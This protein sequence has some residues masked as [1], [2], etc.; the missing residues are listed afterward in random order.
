MEE[1][2][3][4]RGT[5]RAGIAGAS[6]EELMR[7]TIH[8][9]AK[10]GRA[11][12]IGVW[13]EQ[14]SLSSSEPHAAA[15][16]RGLVW[17]PEAGETPKEWERLSLEPPLPQELLASG[18]TVE[19][20]LE[21]SLSR[22]MIGPLVGLRRA[23]WTPIEGKSHLRGLLLTGTRRKQAS[24][25]REL[26]ESVAA[27]LALALE[28]DL[29]QH[30]GQERQA[31]LRLTKHILAALG[32]ETSTDIV[33][34]QLAANC[35]EV[36][37]DGSGAGASFAVIGHGPARAPNSPAAAE[38]KFVWESGDCACTRSV[39]REP[40]ASL[41][42]AALAAGRVMAAEPPAS[43]SKEG[44]ARL[45]AI[46]LMNAGASL[47]VLVAGISQ[48]ASPLATLER[49]E[50]RAM[51]AV[52]AL[53][54]RSRQAEQIRHTTRREALL[55]FSPEATVLLDARGNIAS[56]NHSAKMLL[57]EARAERAPETRL[58]RAQPPYSKDSAWCIGGRFASLFC[59]RVQQRVE[60][61]SSRALAGERKEA[62]EL[63][64]AC[65]DELI[66]G[67]RVRVHAPL[68]A[69]DDLVAV[70]LS[71]AAAHEAAQQRS[72]A[73]T[74]LHNVLEWVEEGIVV[75]GANHTIRAMNT[76]FAQIAGLTPAEVAT[77][78]TLDRLSAQLA[79]RTT[80]PENFAK[81][82]RELARGA[83]GG[84]R[85][86]LQLA[87][88]VPRVL[89][90]SMRPVLDSAGKLLGRIEIY[91]DLTA[92]RVFQAKLIQTEKL[93]AL[94]QMVTGI[95]H[96][97]SNPLTSILGYSQRLL[98]RK[99]LA[100]RTEEARQIYEE[101][102]RASTILRQLLLNAR[103]TRPERK[104]VALNQVVLRAMELQR[105]GSAAEKIR[106]EL[107]LDPTLP[108][109]TGDSGQL[110]QVL[111]NLIGNARQAIVQE[112]KAGTI[113]LRTARSGDHRIILQVIDDG[114]GIPQAILARI[115]DPFFTTK[116][117]GVGTGLGLSIV[118]SVVREHGG[119][120]IVS[121]PPEGGTVFSVELP[122]ETESSLKPGRPLLEAGEQLPAVS[123][124]AASNNHRPH[125][126][127]RPAPRSNHRGTRVLVVEDEPTVARLIADVLED[128]GLHVDVLLDGREALE[129]AG[130]EPFDLVVCDMK[131]PGLDGQH[132]YHSLARA[133]NPLQQRFLFVTGDVIAPQTQEFLERNRLPHVA[134]PFRVEELTAKVFSL[135]DSQRAGGGRAAAAEQ[136][137]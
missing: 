45:V 126:V 22:S 37:A 73:E 136:A 1:G 56:L 40:L 76:R 13:L 63:E 66:T 82:W 35:T 17:E 101:A 107:D 36:P 34:S 96:E 41:W 124:A 55:E 61:W 87:R 32:S 20:E 11:D 43:W 31:D 12:R 58:R 29:E 93:A 116:P 109:V 135:L 88:P 70:V 49:L 112:A 123:A 3:S 44:L 42:R 28:L 65:E 50:L 15:S 127:P 52:S 110:Q 117:V 115:F 48:K 121:N 128:E 9:L 113:R 53:E 106:I 79:G 67:V 97:L 129:R 39:E 104:R 86:E 21:A 64:E 131:M 60:E 7:E 57:Q 118:L 30:L 38:I 100:G 2:R 6:R 111:M 25:P 132:F 122:V 90:R 83:E 80:E 8:A 134:K 120:V 4:W 77:C 103:E 26:T 23:L 51:L 78:T 10:D 81:R 92:E 72:R 46:P 54:R 108:F 18:Q 14:D 119:Q 130:R 62:I 114:P 71:P 59:A 105:F 95:A 68:A 16:L 47:G 19:Q 69:G 89:E 133:R 74:E 125:A 84:T 5:A 33:L 99:H 102:E 75:F 94:G 85:E 24:L 98:V 27:E 137:H 91:R